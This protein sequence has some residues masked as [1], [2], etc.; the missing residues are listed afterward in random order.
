MANARHSEVLV[1][2][3][4]GADDTYTYP[5]P[6]HAR[7][8]ASLQCILNGGSG[9][10]TVTVE[11]SNGQGEDLDA[12]TYSDITNDLFGVS[13]ITVTGNFVFDTPIPWRVIRPK[14]VASTGGAD[15]ADWTINLG[16]VD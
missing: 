7:K 8:Y 6:L 2:V 12:L 11:A 15:D 3:V 9:T 16:L 14:V 1:A 10:V 5:I 13:N 4:N